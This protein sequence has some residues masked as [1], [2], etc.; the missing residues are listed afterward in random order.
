M[1]NKLSLIVGAGMAIALCLTSSVLAQGEK[2]A[3]PSPR[4]SA[5]SATAATSPAADAASS[6]AKKQKAIPFHG[7]ISTVDQT[8]KTFSIGGKEKTRVFRI[9]DRSV[10]TIK[11]GKRW[12]AHFGPKKTGTMANV[13]IGDKVSGWFWKNADDSLE[14][15]SVNIDHSSDP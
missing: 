10:I 12:R 15:K 7:I 8:A 2:G 11:M 14:V 9:T 4:A 6:P 5:S 3:S 13:A 1:T